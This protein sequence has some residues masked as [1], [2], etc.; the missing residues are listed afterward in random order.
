MRYPFLTTAFFVAFSLPALAQSVYVTA[1]VGTEVSRQTRFESSG[2][3][4][5]Q[6]SGA[7]TP[8]MGLRLGTRV[9]ER[10]GVELAF[11]RSSEI[12]EDITNGC[13][14]CIPVL[15]TGGAPVGAGLGQGEEL[16]YRPIIDSVTSMRLR[17]NSVGTMAWVRQPVADTIDLAYLGGLAFGRNVREVTVTYGGL[18]G[19][20]SSSQTTTF[21]LSPV[22]GFEA[23]I[24]MTEHIRLVPGIRMQGTSDAAAGD[25][26]LLRATVGLGWQF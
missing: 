8:V 7:E 23:R 4:S 21:D 2:F 14:C 20:R 16:I 1:A 25:G 12:A 5:N 9:G 15:T 3:D 19:F 13:C 18:G 26:W 11:A 10:W 24:A 6:F 17:H 22:V